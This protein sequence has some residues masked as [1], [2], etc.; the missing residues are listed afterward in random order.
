MESR[1]LRLAPEISRLVEQRL[2]PLNGK[3]LEAAQAAVLKV[4]GS[5]QQMAHEQWVKA[6]DTAIT[7]A[8]GD[9]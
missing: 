8:V 6:Y 7:S 4:Y 9:K 3:Q 5:G 2:K 1:P